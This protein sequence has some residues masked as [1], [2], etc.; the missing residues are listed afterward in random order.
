[1][2]ICS[3]EQALALK[4]AYLELW[5]HTVNGTAEKNILSLGHKV[6]DLTQNLPTDE[7]N[8]ITEE[9][10]TKLNTKLVGNTEA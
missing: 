4:E 9:L 6:H 10:T 8:V 7:N 2:D 1:M 5:H 3:C